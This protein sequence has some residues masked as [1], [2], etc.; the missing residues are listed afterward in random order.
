[1]FILFR[2]NMNEENK[3]VM[4]RVNFHTYILITYLKTKSNIN[5]KG[6]QQHNKYYKSAKTLGCLLLN[7]IEIVSQ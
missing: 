2:T 7:I 4:F 3:N 6:I 5:T 1:M